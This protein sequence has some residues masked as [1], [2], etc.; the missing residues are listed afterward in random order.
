MCKQNIFDNEIFFEGYKNI[1]ANEGN[2]NNLVEKPA[3]F[4]QCPDLKGKKVLDLGCGYGENCILFKKRGTDRVVG[5]DIS[6]KML[7]VAKAK[8]TGDNITYIQMCMENIGIL[9]EHFDV[10]FSSLAMHYI[11]DFSSLCKN[12]FKL[13][14]TGGYFIFSQENPI[15]TCFTNGNRWTKDENGNVIFAN[16]SN[17]S[18]DG[19]RK[20]KWFVDGVIKYHRTFSSI[21]NSLV[22]AGFMIEK[23]CEPVPDIETIKKYPKYAKDIHKPDFLIIRAK[24]H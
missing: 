18:V 7:S 8:N 5:I 9:Q 19:E 16:I 12:V 2:A 10:V 13:L 14:N 23:M 4:S 15:N 24:K 20:S 17:Y 21:I 6:E 11:K 1:R 22:E 3:L